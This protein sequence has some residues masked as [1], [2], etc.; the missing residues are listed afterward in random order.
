MN[1]ADGMVPL[2]SCFLVFF[3]FL[4]SC[5]LLQDLEANCAVLQAATNEVRGS[6]K[7]KI[8]MEVVLATGNYMNGG[9]AR[10]DATTFTLDTLNKLNTVKSVDNKSN[11]LEFIVE[12]LRLKAPDAFSLLDDMSTVRTAKGVSLGQLVV[13]S[14]CLLRAVRMVEN[15]ACG[16]KPKVRAAVGPNGS[17]GDD[18]YFAEMDVFT[19]QADAAGSALVDAVNSLDHD[20][21]DLCASF[22]EKGVK[23]GGRMGSG[24]DTSAHLF[25]V[26]D[27]FLQSYAGA[28]Q[29]NRVRREAEAQARRNEEAEKK[30]CEEREKRKRGQLAA[31]GL[32]GCSNAEG[33]GQ[34][35]PPTTNL[36]GQFR[37]MQKKD[38][39]GI[40]AAFRSRMAHNRAC[41]TGGENAEN[42]EDSQDSDNAW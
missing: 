35:H 1:C 34:Q 16:D 12:S 20:M 38:T 26:F 23:L 33:V 41:I 42:D 31:G 25:G 2:A 17:Q 3:A 29:K 18:P 8:V 5:L 22:G 15:A 21:V 9:S 7:L 30:R 11:L 40:I 13:D 6:A 39:G 14:Q 28:V 36:V 19:K 4:P 10:G 24:E 27:T 32:N 37:D